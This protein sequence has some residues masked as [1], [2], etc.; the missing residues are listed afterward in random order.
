[1]PRQTVG[2]QASAFQGPARERC[3]AFR[4]EVRSQDHVPDR[5]CNGARSGVVDKFR[6]VARRTSPPQR[7]LCTGPAA[8][9]VWRAS[10]LSGGYSS[11]S[12][13]TRAGPAGTRGRTGR[14]L[15]A[16]AADHPRSPPKASYHLHRGCSRCSS[17]LQLYQPSSNSRRP[18]AS[19]VNLSARSFVVR[20]SVDLAASRNLLLAV[21]A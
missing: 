13:S 6:E 16:R 9:Q 7:S 8:Y 10:G 20:F 2:T 19:A 17:A 11:R 3:V 5:R 15:D 4:S 14:T 1:M 21:A 18:S 12:E